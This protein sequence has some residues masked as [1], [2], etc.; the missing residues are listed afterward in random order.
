[1]NE[2][3][4]WF[5]FFFN[6]NPLLLTLGIP[7]YLVET[8][9]TWPN[10]LYWAGLVGLSVKSCLSQIQKNYQ[11]IQAQH[12]KLPPSHTGLEKIRSILFDRPELALLWRFSTQ[13]KTELIFLFTVFSLLLISLPVFNSLYFSPSFFDYQADTVSFSFGFFLLTILTHS[14]ISKYNHTVSEQIQFSAWESLILSCSA[15]VFIPWITSNTSFS[16]DS[17]ALKITTFAAVYLFSSLLITARDQSLH[18]V[19]LSQ[20]FWQEPIARKKNRNQSLSDGILYE[21]RVRGYANR[22]I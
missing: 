15:S 5:N 12:Q 6:L 2:K 4:Q 16:S 20:L 11:F 21:N 7:S 18:H 8:Y 9:D 19:Q 3:R 17:K 22:R 14:V 1:M 10:H 13:L